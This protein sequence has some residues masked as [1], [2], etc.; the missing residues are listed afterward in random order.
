MLALRLGTGL[1]ALVGGLFVGKVAVRS[2][3]SHVAAAGQALIVVVAGSSLF[4]VL[5]MAEGSVAD[6]ALRALVMFLAGLCL[7]RGSP[8]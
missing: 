2:R 8:R 4:V 5:G 7:S 3:T 1:I 6:W